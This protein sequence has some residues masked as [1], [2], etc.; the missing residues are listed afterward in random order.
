MGDHEVL[1]GLAGDGHQLAQVLVDDQ[2]QI[3]GRVH[4][5]RHG[6]RREL[7]HH[8][9]DELRDEAGRAARSGRRIDLADR[10]Q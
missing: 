8:L 5:D 10:R 1:H 3:F 6:L 4:R 2:R 7:V 9:D